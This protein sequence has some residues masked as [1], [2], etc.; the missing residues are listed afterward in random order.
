MYLAYSLLV[1]LAVLLGSPY[2]IYQ[3]IRHRKYVGSL[4]QRLGRLPI[5]LNLDS[6]AS[7][8]IHAVSVGEVL[9]ARPL[10]EAL[11]QRYPM[12]RLYV[13]TTTMTG[14]QVVRQQLQQA[15]DGAFYF[16]FDFAFI[17]RRVLNV[18]RPKLVVLVENEIWP[19]LLRECHRRGV[20]SMIVNG[21]ISARSFPRYRLARPFF[22]RVLAYV[23]RFCMQGEESARRAI[24]LGAD[25]ARVTIT[26]SLK[27]DSATRMDSHPRGRGRVLRFLRVSPDRVVIVAGSTMR[28]EERAVLQA[29]RRIKAATPTAMLILAP[30][31]AE[32]F[33]EAVQLA[34]G[35]GFLTLRRTELAIDAEPR[36]DVV[37]LDTIG[38]LAQVYQLATVAFVGGSLV[39]TGGHNILEPAVFGRPVM[40]GPHM[41]NF[42]VIAATFLAN[43]AAVQVSSARELEDELAALVA[44][45]VRRASVGAAARALVDANRGALDRTI[46]AIVRLLPPTRPATI[47]PFRVVH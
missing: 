11:R 15:I 20:K 3:A 2:F 16:P 35:E 25:P 14:Q 12:L 17:V 37:V 31:H 30:R 9:S 44:D 46:D 41:S 1:V 18:V 7:I 22:A 21:R 13:S 42:A 4:R 33:E 26:G 23:D 32:R 47:H 40:F 43:R 10:V 19:H 38:E 45:P 29:F 36:A 8:W 39:E 5:S 28:G 27:F 24:E 34:A 6:D